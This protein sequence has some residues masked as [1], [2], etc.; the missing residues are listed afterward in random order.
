MHT[1]LQDTG[2]PVH[3]TSL[4]SAVNI[5]VADFDF[6]IASR[7]RI[8]SPSII[9]TAT[10]GALYLAKSSGFVTLPTNEVSQDA[11]VPSL[12]QP[13]ASSEHKHLSAIPAVSVGIE[14]QITIADRLPRSAASQSFLLP[15]KLAA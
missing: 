14:T 11:K 8:P 9:G 3:N 12:N 6:S 10:V 4:A 2:S 15:K 1:P 5:A 7:Y 13:T